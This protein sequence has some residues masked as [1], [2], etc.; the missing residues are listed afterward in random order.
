MLT[1]KVEDGRV[2]ALEPT[3]WRKCARLAVLLRALPL[4]ACVALG[5][6]AGTEANT[7]DL[8]AEP[9][10]GDVDYRPGESV[11]EE[12]EAREEYGGERGGVRGR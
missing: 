10:P 11:M 6:C 3:S 4:V 5:A 2:V 1:E 8:T 12:N 7:D 9:G